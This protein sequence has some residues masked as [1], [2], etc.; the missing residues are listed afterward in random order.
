VATARGTILAFRAIDGH[1]VWQRDL[2]SPAHARPALA[3]DRVYVPTANAQ[4]VALRVDSGAPLWERRIGGPP[5]DILAL[6]DRLYVGSKDHFFY[7]LDSKDGRIA[8]R[9]RTGGDVIGPAVV[10]DDTVY[11]VSLDNVLR[12][13][14][15]GSGVQ[16]W[17]R[18]LP[19]RPVAGPVRANDVILVVGLAHTVRAYNS[20]DGA[21]AGEV[22]TKAEIA[23]SPQ[24]VI[25][26]D[27]TPGVIVVTGDIVTGASVMLVE[28]SIDP[29]AQPFG[30]LPSPVAS[31]PPLA[32]AKR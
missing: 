18:P 28:R 10:D 31:V 3:A 17:M 9:W 23:A 8:W 29:A 4:V 26:S 5:N 27:G 14:A 7:C 11:F 12:A 13:L 1:L 22:P 15:R 30:A 25:R 16:R 21:P 24:V 19:L 6:D 20:K 32:T 2:P